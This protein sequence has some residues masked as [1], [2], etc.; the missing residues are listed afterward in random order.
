MR[1]LLVE[2]FAEAADARAGE[3]AEDVALVVVKLR[4]GFAAEGEEFVA[5]EGLDA[6]EGEV[7]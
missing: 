3:D 7:S 5:E 4:R 1:F 6:G 2:E